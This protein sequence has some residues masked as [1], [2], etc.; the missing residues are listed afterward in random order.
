M[1]SGRREEDGVAFT[2]SGC[3]SVRPDFFSQSWERLV[4]GSGQR[5]I[6]LHDLRHSHASILLKANVPVKIVSERLG[7][8]NPA[9]TM[10]VYQHVLP[11]MQADAAVA[12]GDAVFGDRSGGH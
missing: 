8:S 1:S 12:F 6:R 10:T 3:K 4:R 5:C 11:G 7:H 9:F 2:R